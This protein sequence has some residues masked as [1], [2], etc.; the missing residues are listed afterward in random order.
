ML[1]PSLPPLAPNPAM[2]RPR[3]GQRKSP[4]TLAV[5]SGSGA[6]AFAAS[7]CGAGAAGA[8][9]MVFTGSGWVRAAT[10]GCSTTGFGADKSGFGAETRGSLVAE[11]TCIGADLA[12]AGAAGACAVVV[13]PGRTRLAGSTGVVAADTLDGSTRRNLGCAAA[14]AEAVWTAGTGRGWT[15][16]GAEA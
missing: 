5:A 10:L 16:A 14:W 1:M 3:A 9:A 11:A 2:T 6:G 4:D 8:G 7:G 13:E 15:E 12:G